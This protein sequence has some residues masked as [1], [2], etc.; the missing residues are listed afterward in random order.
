M[1]GY[2]QELAFLLIQLACSYCDKLQNVKPRKVVRCTHIG[3][4]R[5]FTILVM[6]SVRTAMASELQI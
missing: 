1:N 3:Y 2:C 4:C 5:S 6:C